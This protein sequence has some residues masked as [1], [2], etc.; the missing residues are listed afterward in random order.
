[1]TSIIETRATGPEVERVISSKLLPAVADEDRSLILISL[2][3]LTITLMK[4][5]VT[6]EEIQEGVKGMSEWLCLFLA[7][8]DDEGEQGDKRG[9]N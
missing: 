6:G 9:F 3:T 8:S 7:S 4:P 1:M 2:L 5:D